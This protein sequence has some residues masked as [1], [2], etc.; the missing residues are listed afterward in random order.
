[1]GGMEGWGLLGPLD[2][3][4]RKGSRERWGYKERRGPKERWG[5]QERNEVGGWLVD[6]DQL[7]LLA[8]GGKLERRGNKGTLV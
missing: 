6:K 3:Q 5:Y 8:P 2:P 4:E 1:M 7:D